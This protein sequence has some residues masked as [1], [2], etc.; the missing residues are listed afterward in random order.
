MVYFK[1]NKNTERWCTLSL[2]KGTSIL[3][4]LKSNILKNRWPASIKTGAGK[5]SIQ[6]KQW[7]F[8]ET[9]HATFLTWTNGFILFDLFTLL[10]IDDL[11]PS[12]PDADAC[13]FLCVTDFE[14]GMSL[15]AG[16]TQTYVNGL[17]NGGV[18]DLTQTVQTQQQQGIIQSN[19]IAVCEYCFN[20]N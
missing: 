20:S 19:L 15:Y 16:Q 7:P 1:M 4:P 14:S 9:R 12:E 8:Q 2:R 5:Y 13:L 18:M 10:Q 17:V 11:I 6:R 3:K